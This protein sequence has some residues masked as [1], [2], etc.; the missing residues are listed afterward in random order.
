MQLHSLQSSS[1]QFSTRFKGA[2]LRYTVSNSFTWTCHISLNFACFELLSTYSHT[3]LTSLISLQTPCIEALC[4]MRCE[5]LKLVYP[6]AL[7]RPLQLSAK[8]LGIVF[9]GWRQVF[10]VTSIPLQIC[11]CRQPRWVPKGTVG[12]KRCQQCMLSLL[13]EHECAEHR[14]LWFLLEW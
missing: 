13:G 2:H 1:H 10:A 9:C 8:L 3:Y 14:T 5:G 7:L 12:G 6:K 4:I 11:F